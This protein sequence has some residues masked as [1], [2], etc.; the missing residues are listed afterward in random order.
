M[1]HLH[2][3]DIPALSE[4]P[5]CTV[6]GCKYFRLDMGTASNAPTKTEVV[7]DVKEPWSTGA[8]TWVSG[9]VERRDY[10]KEDREK[11]EKGRNK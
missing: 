3:F 6:C 2:P 8:N 11:E 10:E 4:N 9:I 5:S 7:L 1:E